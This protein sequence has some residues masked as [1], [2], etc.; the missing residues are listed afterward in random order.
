MLTCK[1]IVGVM[2]V[3]VVEGTLGYPVFH[4]IEQ[5]ACLGIP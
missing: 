2:C 1:E 5:I 3:C 4:Q